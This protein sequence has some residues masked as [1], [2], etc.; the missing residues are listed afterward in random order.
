MTLILTLILT[1]TK[2]VPVA[3]EAGVVLAIHPDDPPLPLL[4]LPRV[5]STEDD[6]KHLLGAV[7][8]V[9]NGLTFCTGSYGSCPDNDVEGMAERR[10]VHARAVRPGLCCSDAPWTQ[11]AALTA[12]GRSSAP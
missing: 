9:H 1:L 6:V 5:V 12:K 4:G 2:V 11:Q 8:S 7:D 3:E 10:A